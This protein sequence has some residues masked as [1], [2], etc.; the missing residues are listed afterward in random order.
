MNSVYTCVLSLNT[1]L[2]S[3]VQ[4]EHRKPS[5]TLLGKRPL[6]T[7]KHSCKRLN[8]CY[9][10]EFMK[11]SSKNEQEKRVVFSNKFQT[12]YEEKVLIFIRH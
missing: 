3:S 9:S 11:D 6:R 12:S 1:E 5:P 10:S 4:V 7:A 2:N 8:Y